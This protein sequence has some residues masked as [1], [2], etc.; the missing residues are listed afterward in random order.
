MRLG[1]IISK[2]RELM[3]H[4]ETAKQASDLH[5]NIFS[6]YAIYEYLTHNEYME[7]VHTII[8]L[9][10]EQSKI[11]LDA[12]NEYFSKDVSFTVPQGG[13]FIWVTLNNG[14]TALEFFN[15]AME[16]DVAFV[17]GDPFYTSKTN[18]NTLRLNYTN[19]SPEVL[20]EGIKRLANI[21]VATPKAT[22]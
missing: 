17:P 20:I 15:K 3:E 19:S 5:T 2:N 12:L 8:D 7:H 21:L 13:M 6:Q 1:F 4:L 14:M 16:V 9:Y 10:R 22:L 11:M 18:V